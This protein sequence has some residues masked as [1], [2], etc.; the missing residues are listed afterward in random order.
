MAALAMA[1]LAPDRALPY[2]KHYQQRLQPID[3]AP[4]GYR[5]ELDRLLNEIG[6][7]GAAAVLARELPGLISGWPRDAYHPLIR[8]AY[9][10]AFAIDTEIAAGLAYFRLC[11]P[12]RSI[13]KRARSAKR[14]AHPQPAFA[15]MKQCAGSVTAERSF[16]ESVAEVVSHPAFFSAAPL[17]EDHLKAFSRM[18]LEIF[19]STHNFFA[20]HLV[21]GAHAYRTLYSYLGEQRDPVFGLGLLAGYAAVGAPEFEPIPAATTAE[22]A[23]MVFTDGRDGWPD[24]H[25]VKLAHSCLEQA[26]FFGD[27]SWTAVAADY[28]AR[29]RG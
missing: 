24:E 11:G 4:E 13:E 22:P 23:R 3:T 9:G 15:A 1:A 2:L 7:S 21:T 18:A 28:L 8:T 26:R 19:A 20:L 25:D 17:T 12:D 27:D 6:R 16:T 29:R 14:M 5:R 10:V